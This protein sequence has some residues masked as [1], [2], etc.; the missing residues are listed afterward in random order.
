MATRKQSPKLLMKSVNNFTFDASSVDSTTVGE[1]L[2]GPTAEEED[3]G[4]GPVVFICTKC[5]V[6]IGDSLSWD[7]SEDDLNQIRLKRKFGLEFVCLFFVSFS[8][9]F[10][11]EPLEMC[12]QSCLQYFIAVVSSVN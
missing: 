4:D 1:K 9:G 6:P 5:K 8:Q 10:S 11:P 2:F 12:R 3:G 7:G